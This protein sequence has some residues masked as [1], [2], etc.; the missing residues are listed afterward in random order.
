MTIA[1]R[2]MPPEGRPPGWEGPPRKLISRRYARS[3]PIPRTARSAPL[4]ATEGGTGSLAG[5]ERP[6]GDRRQEDGSPAAE[7]P[8]PW[9]VEHVAEEIDPVGEP[10]LPKLGCE[11]P[12]QGLLVPLEP[13]DGDHETGDGREP[14]QQTTEVV[15]L[16]SPG[17]MTSVLR[18]SSSARA[19]SASRATA[20][21]RRVIST[22]KGTVTGS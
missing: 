1:R 2:R 6:E 7:H 9:N 20:K 3:R 8:T 4:P 21:D 17:L 19:R 12:P 5:G 13:P 15:H 10:K 22:T 14:D 18:F 11:R 16:C